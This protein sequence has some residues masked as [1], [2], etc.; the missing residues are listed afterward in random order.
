MIVHTLWD[1]NIHITKSFVLSMQLTSDLIKFYM[2]DQQQCGYF[3]AI[4]TSS[5]N[6]VNNQLK[7][8]EKKIASVVSFFLVLY[9][10]RHRMKM[11]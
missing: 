7:L 3:Y 8:E 10:N 1:E 6:T 4:L 11:I 9:E 5:Y 2:K